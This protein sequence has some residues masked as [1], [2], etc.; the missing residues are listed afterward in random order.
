MNCLRF[1]FLLI[2]IFLTACQTPQMAATASDYDLCSQVY[3]YRNTK[4]YLDEL[5]RRR[6]N[7]NQYSAALQREASQPGF[8]ESIAK[9]AGDAQK[10]AQPPKPMTYIP[11]G[12][13]RPNYLQCEPDGRGGY[14]CR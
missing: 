2:I 12:V 7:C 8:F 3:V 14:Y 6:V 10:Y 4:Y 9:G 13:T 11:P 1:P 5:N